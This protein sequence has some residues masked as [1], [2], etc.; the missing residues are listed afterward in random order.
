M[1]PLHQDFSVLTNLR[2]PPPQTNR[3]SDVIVL[4]RGTLVNT[5]GGRVEVANG[6]TKLL[7]IAYY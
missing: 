5:E 4:S 1:E 2:R 6:N 3:L 7:H